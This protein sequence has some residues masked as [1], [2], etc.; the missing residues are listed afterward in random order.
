[1][2]TTPTKR[3]LP[4]AKRRNKRRRAGQGPLYK[5]TERS[6]KFHFG[7]YKVLRGASITPQGW[8]GEDGLDFNHNTIT[9]NI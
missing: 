5:W 3:K 1:L 6:L 8:M 7:I 2:G 9:Q 4:V